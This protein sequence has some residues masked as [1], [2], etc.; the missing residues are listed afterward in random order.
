MRH[1]ALH[2]SIIH[3]DFYPPAPREATWPT[4]YPELP[5]S[6][7]PAGGHCFGSDL[8]CNGCSKTWSSQQTD[9]T[10]CPAAVQ[11][12]ALQRREALTHCKRGHDL[13]E[14][15]AGYGKCMECHREGKARRRETLLRNAV[16][17][18]S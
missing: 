3:A 10:A 8:V 1:R 2:R 16:K 18:H 12:L 4:S 14:H 15:R 5:V 17:A 6:R 9:P 11:G 13:A 7:S